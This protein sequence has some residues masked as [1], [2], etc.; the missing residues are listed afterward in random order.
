[1]NQPCVWQPAG[2]EELWLAGAEHQILAFW[3]G[4]G[5]PENDDGWWNR[6]LGL[7]SLIG[8]ARKQAAKASS[9]PL[10]GFS[11]HATDARHVPKSRFGEL[12]VGIQLVMW[13]FYGDEAGGKKDKVG[14]DG[15]I[16]PSSLRIAGVFYNTEM[17]TTP[18]WMWSAHNS[19]DAIS[20]KRKQTLLTGFCAGF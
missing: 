8:L 4:G 19:A 13:S 2:C 10:M 11:T 17:S 7:T 9:M 16:A 18:R 5:G 15:L 14:V 3:G 20:D 1:M 12:S 6:W